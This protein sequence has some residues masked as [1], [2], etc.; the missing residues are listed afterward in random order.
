MTI[1]TM[2]LVGEFHAKVGFA[3]PTMPVVPPVAIYLRHMGLIAE[4]FAE[5][6]YA[7]SSHNEADVLDAICDLRYI[8]DGTAR[9]CGLKGKRPLH[10]G[11]HGDPLRVVYMLQADI[12][13]LSDA[14]LRGDPATLSICFRMID[15][16]L[17]MLIAT[18]G[19]QTV[20]DAAFLEVHRSNMTKEALINQRSSKIIKG[21]GFQPPQLQHLITLKNLPPSHV[22]AANEIRHEL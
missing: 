13:A 17:G 2:D 7:M 8:V 1:N 10:Y 14:F 3:E 16:G 18:L 15:T 11:Y 9:M 20:A 12:L 21:A 19:F 22:A 4:E 6:C 5:L